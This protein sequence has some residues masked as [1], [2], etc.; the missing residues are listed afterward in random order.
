MAASNHAAVRGPS[1]RGC[2]RPPTAKTTLS[3]V[4]P[5]PYQSGRC[6]LLSHINPPSKNIGPLVSALMLMS[7][8]HLPLFPFRQNE[9]GI[10]SFIDCA[11]PLLCMHY[12]WSIL[13]WCPAKATDS[14][15][16]RLVSK[17]MFSCSF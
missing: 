11:P 5:Q 4:T 13:L 3:P 9:N 7:H 17:T 6:R 2:G 16:G 15:D 14:R 10:V 8:R 12:K 1:I